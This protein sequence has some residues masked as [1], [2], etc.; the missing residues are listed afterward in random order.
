MDN[1]K[2][3]I[4]DE[5]EYV[6]VR[7]IAKS[8]YACNSG[9]IPTAEVRSRLQKNGVTVTRVRV[10]DGHA[11]RNMW[12]IPISELEAAKVFV[13]GKTG[14][15]A[16]EM[17]ASEEGGC[18]FYIIQKYPKHAPNIIKMGKTTRSVMKR[19]REYNV[20]DTKLLLSHPISPSDEYTLIKQIGGKNERLGDEEFWVKDVDGFMERAKGIM[21]LMPDANDEDEE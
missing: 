16:E 10:T 3:Y 1:L 12:A 19:M 17:P 9:K 14:K 6:L 4:Y 15:P 21:S 11:T 20:Y 2:V 7:D 18:F 13:S 8:V 5:N